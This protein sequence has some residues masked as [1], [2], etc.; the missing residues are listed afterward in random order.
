MEEV[1]LKLYRQVDHLKDYTGL[2]KNLIKIQLLLNLKMVMKRL[3]TD[4]I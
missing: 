3:L 4:L 1:E 2:L